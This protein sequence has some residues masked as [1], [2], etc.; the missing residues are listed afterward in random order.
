MNQ[1]NPIGKIAGEAPQEIL[2]NVFCELPHIYG[3]YLFTPQGQVVAHATTDE[4]ASHADLP[5][6]AGD[7]WQL[8]QRTADA[9]ERG[10]LSF[11]AMQC[12]LGTIVATRLSQG[13]VLVLLGRQ[14]VRPGMVLYDMDWLASRLSPALP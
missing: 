13:H 8:A 1:S 5:G 10:K 7:L 4:T 11:I 14:D 3:V 6:L 12:Q 9:L 2:E